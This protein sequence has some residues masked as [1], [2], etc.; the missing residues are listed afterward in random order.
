MKNVGPILPLLPLLIPLAG[1]WVIW[2]LPMR[3]VSPGLRRKVH[4]G[5]LLGTCVV[6]VAAKS[7]GIAARLPFWGPFSA[8]NESLGISF[9]ALS[10]AFSALLLGS[11]TLVGFSMITR[12]MERSESVSTLL[13]LGAS[14]GVCASTNLL[15][16]C[17][18]WMLMDVALLGMDIVRV[19]DESIPHA[20]RNML[21]NLLSTLV[22]IAVIVWALLQHG[23]SQLTDL[24]LSGLPFKLVAVA[25]LLR[26]G[27][28]PLP[29]SFK[30]RWEVYLASLC[31]GGYLWL[32]L[33]S[34][35]P[36]EFSTLSGLIPLCACALV[37]TALLAGFSS[38][39]A[40][41]LPYILLNGIITFV[42][43]P[44]LNPAIGYGIAYII[45]FNL[46]LCLTLLRVDVQ[47]RLI[48]PWG[49]KARLPLLIA[50]ASLAGGPFTLG[51][52]TH[53]S[54]LKLF[55]MTGFKNLLLWGAMSYLLC[56]VPLWRRLHYF[57]HEVKDEGPAP[58]WGVQVAFACATALA[59]ILIFSGIYPSFLGRPWS[60]LAGQGMSLSGFWPASFGV[61]LSGNMGM[62]AVLALLVIIVPFPASYGL[63]RL[64]AATPSIIVRL[65]DTTT[66]LLELDWFY[67]GMERLFS[68]VG[69]LAE[70]ALLLTE[71][72]LY[73]GW[74]LIWILVVVLYLSGS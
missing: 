63:Q 47:V 29:G 65:V 48:P 54:L 34:L 2:V 21:V 6:L 45:A 30:R 68:R 56:T 39:F 42:L 73:L 69:T 10:F 13:L 41:A 35:A 59:M 7:A 17:L 57:F 8:Y 60:A 25:A 9:D 62:L 66:A 1:V 23:E 38:D 5:I 71:E 44:L 3:I 67:A 61:L 72:D 70:R 16:L 12:P 50:L 14:I 43:A 55:W 15:T 22:L 37:I 31:S 36:G 51:F 26:L 33:I 46:G 52:V 64:R 74:T 58:R 49:R 24:A 11:L 20:V 32:R 28:Y 18:T 4:L 19:P 27:L 53:W 40:M